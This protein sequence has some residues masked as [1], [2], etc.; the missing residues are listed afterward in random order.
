MS[1]KFDPRPE[2]RDPS[3]GR[4]PKPVTR[5]PK[6]ETRDPRS[7]AHL[8]TRGSQ[9]G[10]QDPRHGPL[11]FHGTRDSKPRTLK[12]R[13]G[14]TMIGETGEPKLAPLVEPWTQEP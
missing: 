8:E 6:G 3:Y 1:K 7:R 4:D 5:D 10:T 14:T 13:P 2:T 11:I 12:E 9:C